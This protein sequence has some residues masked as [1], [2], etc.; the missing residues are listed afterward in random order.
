MFPSLLIRNQSVISFSF[1][2]LNLNQEKYNNILFDCMNN[3]YYSNLGKK[4]WKNIYV[5]TAL[6]LK[7]NTYNL[8][9]MQILFQFIFSQFFIYFIYIIQMY[10]IIISVYVA[11]V[12]ILQLKKYQRGGSKQA[13]KIAFFH[14]FWYIQIKSVM[15][16]EEDRKYFGLWSKPYSNKF[17]QQQLQN[18]TKM[19]LLSMFTLCNKTRIKYWQKYQV[20]SISNC[21]TM[22][23]V[24]ILYM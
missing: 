14:P 11:L 7:W 10:L 8:S 6:S 22:H 19:L 15:M 21:L 12:L 3:N 4:L 16:E 5:C 2:H 20:G 18:N 24:L 1:E 13:K 9:L 23:I 17:H